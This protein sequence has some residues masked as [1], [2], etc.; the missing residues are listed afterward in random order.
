MGIH[1]TAVVHPSARLDPSVEVGPGAVIGPETVIGPGCLIGPHCVVE[2][3]TLG[4]DNRLIAGCYV[5]TPPQDLKY[6]GEPTRL[7]MG[8]RN[9]VREGVTLN[10]GTT[11]TRETRIGSR[12][13]FMAL[14]HVAHDCRVGDGIIMANASGLAGHVHVGDNV[15]ISTMIGIHQFVR[16]GRLAM[17]SAGAMVG[18]DIPPF[19]MAQGDRARLRGLNA[20]GLR[21][22]GFSPAAIRALKDAY[23]ELFRPG[24]RLEE[25]AARLRAA[26]PTPEVA[27]LLDFIAAGTR[28]I[29]RPRSGAADAEDES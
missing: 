10:R 5:G 7:I 9:M 6:A 4:R 23:L 24:L 19:C 18:K 3:A 14:S 21:R 1:P 29:L 27:E 11:A 16:I 12:C 26:A 20:I 2:H 15:I 22:A 13:L 25:A 8:D 28:G 17:V